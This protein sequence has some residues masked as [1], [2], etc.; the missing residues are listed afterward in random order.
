MNAHLVSMQLKTT[1]W[2][3]EEMHQMSPTVQFDAKYNSSEFVGNLERCLSIDDKHTLENGWNGMLQYGLTNGALDGT[4][5]W[6]KYPGSGWIEFDPKALTADND[7]FPGSADI[8]VYEPCNYRSNIAY[9]YAMLE[10]CDRVG[11]LAKLEPSFGIRYDDF[12]HP[13]MTIHGVLSIGSAF[14][15]ASSTSLGNALDVIPIDIIALLNLQRGLQSIPYNPVLHDVTMQHIQNIDVTVQNIDRQSQDGQSQDG[16]SQDGQSGVYYVDLIRTIL[17]LPVYQWETALRALPQ[18]SQYRT[19]S[20]VITMAA[21]LITDNEDYIGFVV[22]AFDNILSAGDFEFLKTDFVPTWQR[23]RPALTDLSGHQRAQLANEF[24]GTLLRFVFAFYWQ[25]E[26]FPHDGHYDADAIQ[27][28]GEQMYRLNVIIDDLANWTYIHRDFQQG[29]DTYPGV[30]ECRYQ[31]PHSIWHEQSAL[32]LTDLSALME[33]FDA[34]L[35][36]ISDG[37]TIEPGLF[38]CL[39][40]NDC[41]DVT[42]GID[43]N[44]LLQCVQR[45]PILNPNPPCNQYV[46]VAALVPCLRGCTDNVC[47]MECATRH[48]DVGFRVR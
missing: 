43:L 25:E 33:T 8:V 34:T 6:V 30:N 16:Q 29:I 27:Q 31:Q 22:D 1:R 7:T 23:T 45:I 32:G 21:M 4:D 11:F 20:C 5:E 38:G 26:V 28:A 19:F 10:M 12:T 14:M 37:F 40:F 13:L 2:I 3:I 36:S 15:H 46:N 48:G 42:D 9:T 35:Q 17:E 18:P 39:V 41:I 44:K 24:S 47:L